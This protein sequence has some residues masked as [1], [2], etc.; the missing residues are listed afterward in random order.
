MHKIITAVLEMVVVAAL[1][2]MG[3]EC[4]GPLWP[5]VNLG[6]FVIFAAS[7]FLL[8]RRARYAKR[9]IVC[10]GDNLPENRSGV[11]G[12]RAGENRV[13]AQVAHGL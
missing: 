2:L 8:S 4:D 11:S 5:W 12:Y 9:T 7:V 3:C 6:G 1:V 10:A 13:A